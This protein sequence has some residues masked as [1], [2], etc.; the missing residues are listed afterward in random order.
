MFLVGA[1]RIL[2][3]TLFKLGAGGRMGEVISIMEI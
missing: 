3:S 1:R 2:L